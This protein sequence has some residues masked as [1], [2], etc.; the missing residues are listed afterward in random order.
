M[1]TLIGAVMS[2]YRSCFVAMGLTLFFGIAYRSGFIGVIF[3][4]LSAMGGLCLLAAVNVISP[5]PPQH[6]AFAD[7]PPRHLGATLPR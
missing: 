6:P 2:G 7:L 3:A 1:V 4:I 5:L